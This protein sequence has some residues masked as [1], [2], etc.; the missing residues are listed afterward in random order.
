MQALPTD[1]PLGF[2]DS[3]ASAPPPGVIADLEN[4]ETLR[5]PGLAVLQL[6]LATFVVAVRLYTKKY[7]V[8][9]M[10]AEDCESQK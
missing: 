6:I 7:V 8:K 2:L 5:A 10:L 1:L 3:P 4:P 9:R